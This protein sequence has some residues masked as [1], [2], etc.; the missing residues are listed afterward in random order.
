MQEGV[1]R[2]DANAV[3]DGALC[4]A[5][6]ELLGA[7]MVGIER[8]ARRDGACDEGAA[9]RHAEAVRPDRQA[10][11]PAAIALVG[12]AD[13]PFRAN[14]IREDVAVTPAAV[15]ELRPVV[16]V[17]GLAAIVDRTVD[18]ARS[19]ENLALR[20]ADRARGRS[21]AGL[22]FELPGDPQVGERLDEARGNAD[23][24]IGVGRT[25]FE[26]AH[27][28]AGHGEAVGEDGSCGSAADDDVVELV[29]LRGLACSR[30][31]R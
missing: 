14:E 21:L 5:D 17:C 8:Q 28:L 16:E 22:C 9:D 10:A 19:A 7:V 4:V 25:G 1:R 11:G 26:D 12:L 3:V 29:H 20:D 6:A 13:P 2:A 24:G 27:R 31:R 18:G 15:S 23:P 30:T